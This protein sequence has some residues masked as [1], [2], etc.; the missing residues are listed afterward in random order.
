SKQGLIPPHIGILTVLTA[1]GPLSQIALGEELGVD[2]ATMV[3]LLDTLEKDACIEREPGTRD[4]R[5]K[6][7]RITPKGRR[8]QAAAIKIA[9]RVSESF[10]SPLGPHEREILRKAIPKLVK[11]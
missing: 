5:I 1:S 7:I 4:R 3:K 8:T 11:G 9:H 6:L 10:L 2:K